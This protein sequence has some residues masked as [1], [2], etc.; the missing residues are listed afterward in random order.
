VVVANLVAVP[1]TWYLMNRW[2]QGFPYRIGLSWW[3]FAVAFGAGCVVTLATLS[4]KTIK[5]ALANPIGALRSE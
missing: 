5:A 1:L 3:M 4:V 2:L